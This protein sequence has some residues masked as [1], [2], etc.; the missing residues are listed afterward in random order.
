MRCHWFWYF[1][2]GWS[3]DWAINGEDLWLNQNKSIYIEW[4][5]TQELESSDSE[6]NGRGFIFSPLEKRKISQF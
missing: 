1:E 5:G 4:S 2:N 3:F 6:K